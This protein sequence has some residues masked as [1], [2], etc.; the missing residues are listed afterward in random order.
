VTRV[1]TACWPVDLG[2]VMARHARHGVTTKCHGVLAVGW[3]LVLTRSPW[4]GVTRSVTACC[5]S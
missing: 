5:C 1:V 2:N 3:L 4:H